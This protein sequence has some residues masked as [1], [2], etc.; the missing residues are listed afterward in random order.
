MWNK[1]FII[2]IKPSTSW[3]EVNS[4]KSRRERLIIIVKLQ[5]GCPEEME[6]EDML[7]LWDTTKVNHEEILE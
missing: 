2:V 1:K 4:S 3:E 7:K 6:Q 5:T